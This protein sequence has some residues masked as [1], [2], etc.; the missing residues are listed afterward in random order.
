MYE[1]EWAKYRRFKTLAVVLLLALVPV[2]V[3]LTSLSLRLFERKNYLGVF[4]GLSCILAWVYYSFRLQ[5]FR[6]PRCK[7]PFSASWLY[8]Q[9]IFAQKCVHCGLEKFSNV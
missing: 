5:L 2:G 6:C 4:W 1:R 3:A 8:N 7:R 9:S